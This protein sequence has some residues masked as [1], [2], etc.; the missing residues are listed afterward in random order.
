MT[1]AT[2]NPQVEADQT[3]EQFEEQQAGMP[4]W[5]EAVFPWAVSVTGHLGVFL[6]FA[7]TVYIGSH[8][9]TDD[10]VK[11]IIPMSFADE[12]NMPMVEHPG[13]DG[14]P[15]RD[16]A[17]DINEFAKTNGWAEIQSDENS[18]SRLSGS[19]GENVV[20]LIATGTGGSIGKGSG[21]V[22]TGSGGV[23]APYGT[24]GGGRG[25]GIGFLSQHRH[26]AAE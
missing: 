20:D 10:T 9:P 8:Q 4:P 18:A 16:A 25:I 5:L 11:I 24:P 13:I 7:F 6:I 23:Q 22:G 12:S 17:Q 19:E 21:G 14:D 1:Q 3:E 15:N 2:K 26:G